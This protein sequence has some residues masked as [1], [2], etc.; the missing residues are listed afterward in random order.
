MVYCKAHHISLQLLCKQQKEK[1]LL[2]KQKEVVLRTIDLGLRE[3]VT[4][5]GFEPATIRAEI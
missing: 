4:S 1:I 2:H 3:F 5:A